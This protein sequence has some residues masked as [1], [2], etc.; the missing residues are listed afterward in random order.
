[1][2]WLILVA[3]ALVYEFTAL[4]AWGRGR[5]WRTLSAMMRDAF[6]AW[7]F[8][9]VLMGFVVGGLLVHFFWPY[10]R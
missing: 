10:C 7:P 4:S 2:P 5:G 1:M 3:L 6:K 8:F 9:G